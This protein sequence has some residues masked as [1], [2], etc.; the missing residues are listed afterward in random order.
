MRH[1][2]Q[3][4]LSPDRPFFSNHTEWAGKAD[5]FPQRLR[6]GSMAGDRHFR[7]VLEVGIMI[8]DGDVP[9]VAEANGLRPTARV[10]R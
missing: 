1:V 10:S 6:L 9:Y 8:S 2:R 3:S 5:D 7:Q 4:T